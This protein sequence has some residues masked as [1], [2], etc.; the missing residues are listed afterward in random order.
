MP[1]SLRKYRKTALICI[2]LF[3]VAFSVY[4]VTGEGHPNYYNYYIRLSDAFLHGRLYLLDN[5]SWLNE[6]IPNP[7]GPGY[8]VVYPPL[9]A[10]LMTPIVA[11]FGVG[12]NQPLISVFVG[13]LTVILAYFVA[14]DTLKKPDGT[15]P[16]NSSAIWFA[17]LF[18]FGTIFWWLASNGSV[19]LIAQVFS[20]FFL[21]L[22][23]LEAF[24]KRRPLIMGLLV[25][26][27]FWCRL[28]TILG[29]LFFAGLLISQEKSPGW[30][31]KSAPPLPALLK[32]GVARRHLCRL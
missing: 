32:L 16:K 15:P 23:L 24:N 25:G 4:W 1:P 10:F 11:L 20:M 27:S 5:P 19:W 22:A 17:A 9:P 21:L 6:L 26:A 14:K 29:I 28:P 2:V 12:F 30:R 7:S 3:A 18:G 13:S 8:Y 31:Q